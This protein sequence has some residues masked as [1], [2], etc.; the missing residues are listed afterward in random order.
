MAVD[1]E[2]HI[3]DSETL[4]SAFTNK[5]ISENGTGKEFVFW[6]DI[7]QL[8]MKSVHRAILHLGGKF[9]KG[10]KMKHSM[11]DN[12]ESVKRKAEV[13]ASI[14]Q[15]DGLE[16]PASK[17]SKP[18]DSDQNLVCDDCNLHFNS[19][20]MAIQHFKG[21][22]H[23]LK[24]AAKLEAKKNKWQN[25]MATGVGNL[26]GMERGDRGRVDAITRLG[27]LATGVA[28]LVRGTPTGQLVQGNSL[29]VPGYSSWNS[30]IVN[31]PHSDPQPSFGAG[32]KDWYGGSRQRDVLFNS[33]AAVN[34]KM[35]NT[36]GGG[37][38][39]YWQR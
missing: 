37:S 22:K 5:P 1:I 16:Q 31:M 23:A 27:G 7:C 3:Y 17:R 8:K 30:P 26:R 19:S 18:V 13:H 15:K 38:D 20:M 33:N 36:F 32:S 35:N 4:I 6:C 25:V 9:H 34:G 24:V 10:K 21:K 29:T 12:K 14:K 39:Y 28:G 2:S 11:Q